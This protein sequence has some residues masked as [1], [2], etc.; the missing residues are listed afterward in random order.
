LW[1]VGVVVV[2]EVVAAAV[3]RVVCSKARQPLLLVLPAL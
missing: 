2:A 3:V 1:L